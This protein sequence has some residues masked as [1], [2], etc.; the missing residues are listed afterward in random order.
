MLRV[1]AIE[2]YLG[3]DAGGPEK[4]GTF[5]L[6]K[7]PGGRLGLEAPGADVLSISAEGAAAMAEAAIATPQPGE[8]GPTPSSVYDPIRLA[9][10]QKTRFGAYE[11]INERSYDHER[12]HVAGQT[13]HAYFF[14][15]RRL[16]EDP[17]GTRD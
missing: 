14:R 5:A 3:D 13:G 7:Q 11:L 1:D 15:L 10:G 2:G 12:R 8:N 9:P 6:R 17:V 16:G 4:R